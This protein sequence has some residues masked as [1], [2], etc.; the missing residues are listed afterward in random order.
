MPFL[1]PRIPLSRFAEAEDQRAVFISCTCP[2]FP[3]DPH[4]RQ[5]DEDEGE[6]KIPQRH[7]FS[8]LSRLSAPANLRQGSL[9]FLLDGSGSS[10]TAPSIAASIAIGNSWPT[11]VSQMQD[12][13]HSLLGGAAGLKAQYD[14]FYE[15][16]FASDSGDQMWTDKYKPQTTEHLLAGASEH[17][18][19]LSE[20]LGLWKQ[21][22]CFSGFDLNSST[23]TSVSNGI[24]ISGTPGCSKSATVRFCRRCCCYMN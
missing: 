5:L 8:P 22:L 14:F 9:S 20:W 24:L 19:S 3:S 1:M 4:V 15:R 16:K 11:A 12:E 17:V 23:A 6:E 10:L 18:K 7:S 2:I 21:R 13:L